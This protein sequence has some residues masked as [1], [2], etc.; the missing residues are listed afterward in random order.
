MKLSDLLLKCDDLLCFA[1]TSDY[2]KGYISN[3]RREIISLNLFAK[4]HPMSS[5]EEYYIHLQSLAHNKPTLSSRRQVFGRIVQYYKYGVLP[6]KA[7]PFV[8]NKI[9]EFEALPK[10]F[11]LFVLSYV[12]F[13]EFNNLKTS[14]INGRR[15]V[16]VK[17][18][19]HL[20]SNDITKFL[21]LTEAV[22]L[23]YFKDKKAQNTGYDI[24][25]IL[26]LAANACVASNIPI[27]GIETVSRFLP[28][29]P[30]R[31]LVYPYLTDTEIALILDVLQKEESGL[32]FR[33]RAI[34]IMLYYTGMRRGDLTNFKIEQIDW[35]SESITFYQSKNQTYNTLA[36]RPI[37][38][39][40]IF[41]YIN[42]ERPKCDSPYLFLTIDAPYRNLQGGTIY[43]IL[44][45]IFRKADVRTDRGR[46]GTHI[47][48]HN[49][50]RQLINHRCDTRM[51]TNLLGHNSAESINAYLQTD[52][53]SLK[54]CALSIEQFPIKTSI[55]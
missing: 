4:R 11:K 18:L 51:I 22:V 13:M 7:K 47:F 44:D 42:F 45:K 35:N 48:R 54:S 49:F 50:T 16:L 5:F 38:G 24:V 26:K 30:K 46:K 29:L 27:T 8:F 21:D 17:F 31:H 3:L 9:D 43:D 10:E 14:T 55:L 32:S 1:R 52:Y 41:D 6:S 19:R 28:M 36:L 15:G 37:V 53:T 33:D 12:N 23:S 34:G 2:S 40:A 25:K 39:N 20:Q